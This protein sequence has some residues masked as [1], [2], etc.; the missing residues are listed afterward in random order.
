[1]KDGFRGFSNCL[2]INMLGPTTSIKTGTQMVKHVS[3]ILAKKGRGTPTPK[4]YD[5]SRFL[6]YLSLLCIFSVLL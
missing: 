5:L 1:M 2:D 3:W 4:M 6:L